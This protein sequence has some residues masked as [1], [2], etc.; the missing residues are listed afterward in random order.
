M[1]ARSPAGALAMQLMP[2]T[3]RETARRIGLRLDHLA[4][5]ERP[6]DNI[7][8]GSAYLAQMIGRFGGNFVMAAAAYNAGPHR[9]G[10]WQGDACRTAETWIDT[11]PFTETRRYVRRALFYA[12][13]YEWR[14]GREITRLADVMPPIPAAGAADA[15]QCGAE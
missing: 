3:A 10:Q 6:A 1:T 14:L 15:A 11:I 12:A 9:V 13:V 7:A 5:L 4:Q 2:A 8:L